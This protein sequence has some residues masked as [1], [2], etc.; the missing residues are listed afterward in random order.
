[1]SQVLE[2]CAKASFFSSDSRDFDE[3]NGIFVALPGNNSHG[4]NYVKEVLQKKTL[5]VFVAKG[6]VDKFNLA[7]PR[8][9]EV[10]DIRNTH[11]ELAGIFRRKFKTKIVAVAGSNGKSSTKEFLA[12][13]FSSKYKCIQ[14]QASQNGFLGIPKTLEK[15][16]ADVEWA[17]VEVGI[18]RPGDMQQHAQLLQADH[19]LMVSIG[20]EHMKEFKKI[21]TVLSE[22]IKLFDFSQEVYIPSDETLLIAA[23]QPKW[24]ILELKQSYEFSFENPII[25]RNA[26]L[27]L[28]FAEAIA[29][30]ESETRSLSKKLKVL[31]QRGNLLELSSSSKLISDYYNSNPSSLKKGVEG[32]ILQAEKSESSLV[33]ILGDMLDLGELSKKLHRDCWNF[34]R[35]KKAHFDKVVLIGKEW[36]KDTESNFL[37][38]KTKEDFCTSDLV[39]DLKERKQLF[40]LKASRA[41]EFESLL[42]VL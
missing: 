21:E 41:M 19:A 20:Y 39:E 26:T 14:T 28:A 8:I 11:R 32:A 37:L 30:D 40:Y 23:K 31:K 13:I 34:L 12:Q 35:A 17:I 18:D 33:L 15:L 42:E 5:A 2:I 10:E 38:F 16:R 27:A 7:D 6:F 24:K 1:V 25:Q 9:I 3:E 29:F 4:N 36:P 22:E